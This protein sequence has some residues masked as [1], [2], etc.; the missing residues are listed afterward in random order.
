MENNST[1]LFC[2]FRCLPWWVFVCPLYPH[3]RMRTNHGS[4]L[5]LVF[6]LKKDSEAQF[7][8]KKHKENKHSSHGL[9]LMTAGSP[10]ARSQTPVSVRALHS[11]RRR[12]P[13]TTAGNF[14]KMSLVCDKNL[15]EI[16]NFQKAS[17]RLL[18][19]SCCFVNRAQLFCC[20]VELPIDLWL[21]CPTTLLNLLSQVL[22]VARTQQ[23]FK[24][25]LKPN[26]LPNL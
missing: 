10:D 13:P 22:V 20:N 8:F 18:V 12:H 4:F 21:Q 3:H 14:G 17:L 19:L 5:C 26:N 7:D 25:N 9:M 1:S 24:Q 15:L 2:V 16:D 11:T 6:N 23:F